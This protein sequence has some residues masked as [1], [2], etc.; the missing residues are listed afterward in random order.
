MIVI[1]EG[2]GSIARKHIH[3]IKQLRPDVK[4]YGLRSSLG[5][6]EFQ[7]VKNIYNYKDLQKKPDFIVISNPT[8]CHRKSI[9]NALE[10]G[11]PIM[12]EKPVFHN[13]LIEEDL[14]ISNFIKNNK[15]G[16]YVACNLRFHPIIRFLKEYLQNNERRINEVNVYCGSYFPEWRPNRDY[17]NIYSAKDHDG[18]GI[19]LEL[20]HELDYTCWI[21]GKPNN[22]FLTLTSNSSI[23]IEASDYAHYV[24]GYNKF[25]ATI[26]LNFFRKK[27]KRLIE[28]VFDDEVWE[29]NILEGEILSDTNQLIFKCDSKIQDTYFLQMQHMFDIVEGKT[30]SLNTFNDS[31]DILKIALN[32][33]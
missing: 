20:I 31:L 17:K 7:D 24:L 22:S 15:I 1:I 23:E 8:H 10:I 16:T 9:I 32:N 30:S 6:E 12:I 2:L 3:A 13:L 14:A 27:A 4:L 18:G 29:A 19:H 26:T 5:A 21:F 25:V 28:I 11:V 33:A